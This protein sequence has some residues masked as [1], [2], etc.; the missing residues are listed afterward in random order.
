MGRP[1]IVIAV[2]AILAAY[3]VYVASFLPALL[4]GTALP[5]LLVTTIVKSVLAFVAAW[6][7]WAEQRWASGALILLGVMI[8]AT[9]LVEG[10]V[11]GLVAY[12]RALVI[13]VLAVLLAV[14]AAAYVQRQSHQHRFH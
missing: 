4:V 1:P 6:G 12:L 8:A 5:F 2:A 14:T 13:A 11:L 3:G 10:F 9:W 7:V